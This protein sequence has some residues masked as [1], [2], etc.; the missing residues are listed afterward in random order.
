M[1]KE[2]TCETVSNKELMSGNGRYAGYMDKYGSIYPARLV[3]FE[4]T[5]THRSLDKIKVQIEGE[6]EP[7]EFGKFFNR[8][9]KIITR[10]D[11]DKICEYKIGETFFTLANLE[12]RK[13]NGVKQ[14]AGYSLGHA[15]D[16]KG[17]K[18]TY[19]VSVR[20]V[21]GEGDMA[22]HHGSQLMKPFR[23]GTKEDALALMEAGA[24]EAKKEFAPKITQL[25]KQV[26]TATE[27]A[28]AYLTA[29]RRL[30]VSPSE[31]LRMVEDVVKN[32]D[33]Y[34]RGYM[35]DPQML[36][37]MLHNPLYRELFR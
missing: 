13:V 9:Y 2:L 34:R 6:P 11:F 30:C 23:Q 21:T 17:S 1:T 20:Y 7:T 33:H 37:S 5:E 36:A 32:G 24:E 25:E 26:K 22:V 16:V 3:F 8:H 27:L 14:V 10:A 28:A 31:E 15:A 35:Q 12:T 29:V 18:N 19:M 4:I